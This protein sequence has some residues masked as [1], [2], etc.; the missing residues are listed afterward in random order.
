MVDYPVMKLTDDHMIRLCFIK[1]WL[2]FDC[3][4]TEI[5]LSDKD[6]HFV[7]EV[8]IDVRHML[9]YVGKWH[10]MRH[11]QLKNFQIG[12]IKTCKAEELNSEVPHSKVPEIHCSINDGDRNASRPKLNKPQMLL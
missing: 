6:F 12:Q 3:I 5:L 2:A 10:L 4:L 1:I 11:F 8:C 9:Q 7:G